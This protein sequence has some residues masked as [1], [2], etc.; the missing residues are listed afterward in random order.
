MKTSRTT[1]VHAALLLGLATSLHATD[2]TGKWK[3]E[4]DTQIGHLNYT[5]DLKLDGD[6]LT[7]K[8][9]RILDGATTE[10]TITE[11]KLTG[12]AISFVEPLKVQDQDIRIEYN[13]KV[14]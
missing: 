11:G 1:F 3:S 13:G 4:F 6:K 2:V 12:D 9:I 14:A 7:G 10:I 5:Y 8:S